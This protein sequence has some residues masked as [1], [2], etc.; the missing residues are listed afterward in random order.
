[1]WLRLGFLVLLCGSVIESS[2]ILVLFP[3][4]AS[5]QQMP[6]TALVEALLEK[7]HQVTLIGQSTLEDQHA[8]YSYAKLP[9][10]YYSPYDV[11]PALGVD[12]QRPVTKW[13]LLS[14]VP[15]YV[16]YVESL[17]ASDRFQR[18]RREIRSQ[19]MTFDSVIVDANYATHLSIAAD[20]LAGPGRRPVIALSTLPSPWLFDEHLGSFNH[21]SFSPSILSPYT[22]RMNVFQKIENWLSH[23]Y[24]KYRVKSIITSSAVEHFRSELGEKTSEV[25][26][27]SWERVDLLLVASNSIY[28]YPRLYGPNVVEV[29]PLH[30]QGTPQKL[31]QSVKTFLD[32]AEMGVIYFSLGSHIRAK[33]LTDYVIANF[34]RVFTELPRGY[35][36]L[37]KW[38]SDDPI[39]GHPDYI[40]TQK[41]IQQQSVLAH[42]KVKVFITHGGLQS[43]QEAV[44]FG[45][46]LIGIPWFADQEMTVQKIIDAG[47]G[48]KLEHSTLT[49]YESI[50]D[51]V[52][53][54]LAD[55]NYAT[56]SRNMEL[57]SGRSKG[58]TAKASDTATFWVEY[59]TKVGGAS[60]LRP[61]T[62]DATLIEYFCFDIFIVVTILAV[63]AIYGGPKVFP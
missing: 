9:S 55:E 35:R 50:R 2:N 44:H 34:L 26:D 6:V 57:L 62:A 53:G 1:M 47:V 3:S 21:L 39:P 4:L 33:S 41:W 23:T 22:D 12:L 10:E 31:S 36:V 8:N 29:G 52:H 28:N 16:R 61:S 60:H 42:P 17:L 38:E 63:T 15:N 18:I 58:L 59:V 48:V 14:L 27:A 13:E 37:W 25:V 56:F 43:F 20:L 19:N 45:V 54:F 24:I 7:G 11:N 5:G 46:P 32:G 49:S 30:I 40:L 51:V